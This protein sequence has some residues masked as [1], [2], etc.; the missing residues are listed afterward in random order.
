MDPVSQKD[1]DKLMK[2]IEEY[3]DKLRSICDVYLTERRKRQ[4]MVILLIFIAIPALYAASFSTLIF[5]NYLGGGHHNIIDLMIPFLVL[6]VSTPFAIIISNRKTRNLYDAHQ[7]ALTVEKLLRTAS[8]YGEH[9]IQTLGDKF[10][11]DIR[12]AE[13]EAVLQFYQK[14]FHED[15]KIFV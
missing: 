10:E 14:T 6:S 11:F 3:S 9:S 2:L 15:K 8:Q 5:L 12:L 4:Q 13:A 7:I 1:M